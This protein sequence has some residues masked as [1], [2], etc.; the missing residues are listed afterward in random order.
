MR[1][2]LKYR[3]KEHPR[4]EENKLWKADDHDDDDDDDARTKYHGYGLICHLHHKESASF[5]AAINGHKDRMC[6]CN[7]N[8]WFPVVFVS[9]VEFEAWFSSSARV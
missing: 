9:D 7:Y 8:I 5:S 1:G 4:S 6:S 2:A 3:Y